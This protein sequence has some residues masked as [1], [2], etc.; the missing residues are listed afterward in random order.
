M[1][2]LSDMFVLLIYFCACAFFVNGFVLDKTNINICS[3]SSWF[4]FAFRRKYPHRYLSVH[5]PTPEEFLKRATLYDMSNAYCEIIHT[6]ILNINNTHLIYLYIHLR[7]YKLN[8]ILVYTLSMHVHNHTPEDFLSRVTWK[9]I[10]IAYYNTHISI[11][12]NKYVFIRYRC[13]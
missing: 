9:D 7:I 1:Q 6:Y 8:L 12:I 2:I 10:H 11:H 3:Y 13:T 4:S 5:E